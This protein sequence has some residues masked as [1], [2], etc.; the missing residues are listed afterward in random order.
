M[1]IDIW[2]YTDDGCEDHR[3]GLTPSQALNFIGD[4]VIAQRFYEIFTGDLVRDSIT[5][6][7]HE[8]IDQTITPI[9]EKLTKG[10]EN[11]SNKN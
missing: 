6:I 4:A 2:I 7:M 1:K 3:E 9:I 11:E 5:E 8:S 10:K